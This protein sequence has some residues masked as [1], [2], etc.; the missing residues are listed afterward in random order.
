VPP[1]SNLAARIDL[2]I[3]GYPATSFLN[4]FGHSV[5]PSA[6]SICQSVDPRV[7]QSTTSVSTSNY[8]VQSVTRIDL[9]VLTLSLRIP[10]SRLFRY[11]TARCRTPNQITTFEK[12]IHKSLC[13][14][15]VDGLLPSIS[16]WSL[17][18][19]KL[20][21]IAPLLSLCTLGLVRRDSVLAVLLI[22]TNFSHVRLIDRYIL[23]DAV[24][25]INTHSQRFL[26][27]L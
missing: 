17:G 18:N 21:L 9:I 4:Y 22:S 20:K 16:T 8:L 10:F 7:S 25:S 27:R 3:A 14:C 11:L 5:T 12:S 6:L 24:T 13:C 15:Q 2:L 26:V 23:V 1:W 19:W